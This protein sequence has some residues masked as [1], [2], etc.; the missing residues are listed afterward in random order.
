MVDSG[1]LLLLLSAGCG[2]RT[3]HRDSV[4]SQEGDGVDGRWRSRSGL[5]MQLVS[6]GL[7]DSGDTGRGLHGVARSVVSWY[8]VCGRSSAAVID[9]S[10][11]ATLRQGT[12]DRQNLEP[13]RVCDRALT[14][15]SLAVQRPEGEADDYN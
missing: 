12:H 1:R 11:Q 4:R 7:G 2:L 15:R 13:G 8:L 3:A 5:E 10:T 9:S 14:P 6:R